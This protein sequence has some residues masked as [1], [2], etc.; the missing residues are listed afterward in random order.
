MDTLVFLDFDGVLNSELFFNRRHKESEAGSYRDYSESLLPHLDT[1]WFVSLD[2]RNQRLVKI[3]YK[4][5]SYTNYK[6]LL[7]L[8]KKLRSPKIVLSTSWRHGFYPEDWNKIFHK[9]PDWD[10]EIIGCTPTNPITTPTY[11]PIKTMIDHKELT[12]GSIMEHKKWS[13]HEEILQYVMEYDCKNKCFVNYIILDD[14]DVFEGTHQ[15]SER[16]FRTRRNSGL[17]NRDVKKIV[18]YQEERNAR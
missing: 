13:R 10:C 16:F 11:T 2:E 14:D 4:N 8:L 1:E 15:K 6:I 5:I 7:K 17:T 18:R 9:L 12:I 3:F